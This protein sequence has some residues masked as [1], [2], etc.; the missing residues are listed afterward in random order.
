MSNSNHWP[1]QVGQW[2]GLACLLEATA[3]KPGNVHRGADFE[4]LTYLD[5]ATSA[6]AIA[7]ALADAAAGGRLGPCV[8]EAIGATRRAVGTNTNLGAVLLLVPLAMVP[9]QE[10]LRTGVRAILTR[11]DPADA[12]GVY[13]AIRLA[14]PGGLGKVD[15]ADITDP[16]PSDLLYAM[17]LAAERDLVARQYANNF[18]EI[19]EC[20]LPELQAGV[21]ALWPLADTI[22]HTHLRLL[23]Q[24]PDSLIAR[25]CGQ[26]I[27]AQATRG[28]QRVLAAGQPGETAYHEA[29]ADLDF[30]LRADGHRRN[31]GTSA[32]LITAGLFAALREG[33]IETPLNFYAS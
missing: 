13:E 25:K 4:D 11:L 1:Q 16:P 6:L 24:H 27:A 28:A 14:M 17:R 10:S 20:V 26:P 3:P 23:S 31:P 19:F 18:A 30:W 32:D 21:Q 2:G 9:R 8:R 22:V 5:F 33:I 12:Q 7:P 29:L 15:E